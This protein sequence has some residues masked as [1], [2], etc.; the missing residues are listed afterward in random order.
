MTQKEYGS[1]GWGQLSE[2]FELDLPS[3]STVLMRDLEVTELLDL[4]VLD[5]M[6]KFTQL[7]L[8]DLEGVTPDKVSD[9]DLKTLSDSSEDFKKIFNTI[10]RICARAVVKPNVSLL[11]EG[12]DPDPEKVYANLIP[13]NDRIAIF[14]EAVDNMKDL[15]QSGEGQAADVAN[16]PDVQK[17]QQAPK[18]N[19]RNSGKKN[20]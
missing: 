17:L 8:P 5:I 1:K 3:G 11:K 14:E 4:G 2:F 13:L 12:E 7:A 19:P 20:G 10:D 16:L 6:D 15:F 9:L 18:R